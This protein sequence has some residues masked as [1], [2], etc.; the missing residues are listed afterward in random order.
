MSTRC[1]GAARRMLSSGTR[2][3]PPART[4]PSWP[5]S[6]SAARASATVAGRWYS[7]AGGFIPASSPLPCPSWE[8]WWPNGAGRAETDGCTETR[9]RAFLARCSE[10]LR[11]GRGDPAPGRHPPAGVRLLAAWH[12]RPAPAV[13][14]CQPLAAGLARA[15]AGAGAGAAGAVDARRDPPRRVAGGLGGRRR[16]RRGPGRDRWAA[17]L[18]AAAADRRRRGR[19]ALPAEG[20]RRARRRAARAR[21]RARHLPLR[22]RRPHGRRVRL[23]RLA[24]PAALAGGGAA[25]GGGHPGPG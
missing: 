10:D 25:R 22:R 21:P 5:T 7:N 24:V 13:G 17:A 19:R 12:A 6:A 23:R 16:R 9:L 4:L 3:C 18:A 11:D 1:A 20:G 15:A 8:G 2:L 14:R